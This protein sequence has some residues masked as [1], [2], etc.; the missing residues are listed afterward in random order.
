MLVFALAE[1][2]GEPE[3]DPNYNPNEEGSCR[4]KLAVRYLL[5]LNL[6]VA[7]GI[8]IDDVISHRKVKL[9]KSIGQKSYIELHLEESE[10]AYHLLHEKAKK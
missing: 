10:S 5:D 9:A 1:A 4:W 3:H 6:P 2:V 8:L 7:S